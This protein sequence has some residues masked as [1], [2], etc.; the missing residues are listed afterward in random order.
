MR[1]K[2]CR[3]ARQVAEWNPQ[4]KGRHSR[5]VNTWKDVI[6]A[7]LQSRNLKDEECFD[8]ELWRG[9]NMSLV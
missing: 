9:K 4:G 1:M 5:A 2:D 7:S 6:R 3:I 8:R